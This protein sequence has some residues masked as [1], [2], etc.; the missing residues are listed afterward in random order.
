[1]YVVATHPADNILVIEEVPPTLPTQQHDLIQDKNEAW[2]YYQKFIKAEKK[3]R[4]R[5]AHVDALEFFGD[6][7]AYHIL[8]Y[9]E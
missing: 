6:A 3:L 1:M 4:R 2:D 5:R 9:I 7:S 8:H